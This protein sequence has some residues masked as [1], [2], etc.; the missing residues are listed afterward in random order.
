MIWWMKKRWILWMDGGKVSYEKENFLHCRRFCFIDSRRLV[1][2]MEEFY[3]EWSILISWMEK[4]FLGR[5]EKGLVGW[6]KKWLV[7]W[8]ERIENEGT[9][10]LSTTCSHLHNL[11]KLNRLQVITGAEL[12]PHLKNMKSFKL[13]VPALVPQHVHH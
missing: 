7:G 11:Y 1:W 4:G 13:N 2:W 5:M 10:Q 12:V 9:T 8:T 3:E 6:I